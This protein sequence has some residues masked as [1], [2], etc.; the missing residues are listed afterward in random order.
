MHAE[1]GFTFWRGKSKK[2]RMHKIVSYLPTKVRHGNEICKFNSKN[3]QISAYNPVEKLAVV[4]NG[5]G[6]IRA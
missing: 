3:L 4:Y 1:P 5:K 6:R 2:I